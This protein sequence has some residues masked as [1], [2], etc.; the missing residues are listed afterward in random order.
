[1]ITFFRRVLNYARYKLYDQWHFV[2]FAFPL[3]R[4]LTLSSVPSVALR[5]ATSED[6]P[7]IKQ[8]LFLYME[9]DEGDKEYFKFLG[10]EG[11]ECF[12]VERDGILVN[13]TWLFTDLT[14]APIMRTPLPKKKLRKG[15]AFIGPIFTRPDV[16]GLWIFPSVL[17]HIV[18]D[19]KGSKGIYRA[20]VFV[21]DKNPGAVRFY[22]RLGFERL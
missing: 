12:L 11:I 19:L 5:K 10:Q 16:R 17:A 4:E 7:K 20:L 1:M 3:E 2:Y 22:E 6:L 15:D 18:D 21:Y 14:H 13:F 9:G 8:E